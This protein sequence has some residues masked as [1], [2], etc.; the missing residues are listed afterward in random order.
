[1]S[2]QYQKVDKVVEQFIDAIRDKQMLVNDYELQDANSFLIGYLRGTLT[3]ILTFE[4]SKTKSNAILKQFER[5]IN[6]KLQ[7]IENA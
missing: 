4:V 5:T 6:E 7:E 2:V 3:D 1:M